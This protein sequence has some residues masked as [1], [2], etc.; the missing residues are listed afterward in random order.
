MGVGGFL[1]LNLFFTLYT[2]L[3]CLYTFLFTLY[4]FFLTLYTF[5]FTLYTFIPTL[6]LCLDILFRWLFCNWGFNFYDS[7]LWMLGVGCWV[8]CWLNRCVIALCNCLGCLYGFLFRF[9]TT[10]LWLSLCRSLVFFCFNSRLNCIFLL[11]SLLL[12]GCSLTCCWFS[13]RLFC[14]LLSVVCLGNYHF[15][16]CL[17]CHLFKIYIG[18]SPRSPLKGESRFAARSPPLRGIEGG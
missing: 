14:D 5:F 3:S 2:F 16:G 1:S 10:A 13:K 15:F 18:P 8:L 7:I 9:T 12:C 4:T 17:F 6:F 11:G